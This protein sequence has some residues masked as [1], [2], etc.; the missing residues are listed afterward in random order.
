MPCSRTLPVRWY[1]SERLID[2]PTSLRNQSSETQVIHDVFYL[3]H[4][5]LDAVTPSSQ[6]VI[7]EVEDLESSMKIFDKLADHQ[8]SLV[9]A[10]RHRVP[11]KTSLFSL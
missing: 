11:C 10:Q 7:L 6:R 5:V 2:L 4:F 9:V 3:P 8:W 1:F